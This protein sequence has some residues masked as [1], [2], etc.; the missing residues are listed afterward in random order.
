MSQPPLRVAAVQLSSQ[1][2]VA[3]N[4]DACAALVSRAAARGVDL[5]LLPENF[6]FF[7]PEAARGALAEDLDGAS[8]PI[9]RSLSSLARE[10]RL[11]IVGGGMPERSGDPRRP[12]NTAV[13]YGPGGELV[14]RYR[15]IH[16]F[17]VE[18]PDGSALTESSGT[19]PGGEPV[20]FELL[21]RSIGLS[22]CYDLRFPELYRSLVDLGATV[23]LVPAAFTRD[24]G[25]DHWH[26]L[27][28][29]RAIEAQSWVVAA[30]QWGRHPGGRTTYGHSLV[31]DPWGTVVAD[32][33]DREGVVYA[34]L[35]D[36]LL[37][38][39]RATFPSLRHRRLGRPR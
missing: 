38:R 35:D 34:E 22:I 21:G 24:T 5:V 2:D 12:F 26:A 20:V 27:L 8:G 33:S 9:G 15:K 7:G 19:S 4:L 18:L 39:I 30:G 1:D 31:V 11:T 25:K 23:L 16:L 36:D 10:H 28:R 14:T 17:D 13:V 37:D 3:K 6:A 29:A 32:A